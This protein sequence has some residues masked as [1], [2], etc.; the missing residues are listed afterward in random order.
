MHTQTTLNISYLFCAWSNEQHIIHVKQQE[1][2]DTV[3]SQW[4]RQPF[5]NSFQLILFPE[6]QLQ[7]Q[8]M[9]NQ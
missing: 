7:H 2:I 6:I 1:P 8:Y 3:V 5:I 4:S 9:I